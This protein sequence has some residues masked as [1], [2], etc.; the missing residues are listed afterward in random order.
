[1]EVVEM[2]R[3]AKWKEPLILEYSSKGLTGL[4]LQQVEP[5]IVEKVG[6]L[7]IPKGMVR[8]KPINLP[9][10]PEVVVVR[11]YTRLSQM[12]YG[13]DNGPVPLGSCTMKYNPRLAWDIAFDNRITALHPL[14]D[15]R[16]VQGL[17]Q[18]LFELQKWLANITGM[19]VCSLHPAAGAHGELAG[20][21][22]IR[23]YHELKG[24]LGLKR[25]I[26]IP[27]SAHGTNPASASMAGF[28][29][30][31]VAT[32]EDGNVDFEALKSVV[33]DATAGLMITNPSTLGLFEERIVEI[34]E[35]FHKHDALLYYDGAN[36]NGMMGYAR[37]GDMGFDIA[38]LNIHK[39]FSSPHG[40]GGPGAGV[41]CVKDRVVDEKRGVRLS[42]LI[43]GFIIVYDDKTGLYKLREPGPYSVGLIKAF[44][45]NVIPL[46]W[47]YVYIAS[48]GPQGL[49]KA[50]EH[51]VMA[52][53]YF[54]KLVEGVK[55]LEI[56]FGRG[57]FRK[58][59]V[60]LSASKLAEDTGVTAMEVAKGLLDAGFYAPTVYFPLIVKEA[61][62]VE[63]TEAESVENIERY[64][65]R[66]REISKI[67]YENPE[68]AK[69]WPSNTSVGLVDYAK[70]D[71]PKTLSPTWRVYVKRM[72]GEL[73]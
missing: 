35:L 15:E 3:Q 45:G 62:Q 16:T 11:H 18:M 25:E 10:L 41:V 72:R 68:V 64:A 70:G 71:H 47:A 38:H 58:H 56:P 61:L 34:A 6:G 1:L 30:I 63:F 46:V 2:F 24:N 55:G 26:V 40:G 22:T 66:L 43:P 12:S 36:L 69:S 67:A 23:R 27:D 28:V 13:V 59:E 5:R 20:V 17:L 42:D 73:S 9:D 7:K 49:R 29:T 37:P 65:D 14:Q 50:A 52:T 32:G 57:R 48:L 53:N 8:E 21:L 39:T 19:D 31:T 4:N 51:A 54:A 60:V 44:F 33:G